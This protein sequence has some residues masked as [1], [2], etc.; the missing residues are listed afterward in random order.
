ML[1]IRKAL[2]SAGLERLFPE[3]RGKTLL[4]E[5][6][7]VVL[8]KLK[9][10]M[11]PDNFELF[12]RVDQEAREGGTELAGVSD[13]SWPRRGA[14]RMDVDKRE[15]ASVSLRTNYISG[16]CSLFHRPSY[17]LH[18]LLLKINCDWPP[19]RGSSSRTPNL[20]WCTCGSEQRPGMHRN[21]HCRCLALTPQAGRVLPVLPAAS[22]CIM[23]EGTFP[24]KCRNV[25]AHV[26][27]HKGWGTAS[28]LGDGI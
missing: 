12:M 27:G 25:T 13:A 28:T 26:T 8:L 23:A 4:P 22:I 5:D 17:C 15:R 10:R 6:T 21:S 14:S 7:V 3:G 2:G 24:Q 1:F 11:P 19:P 16:V 20:Q 18:P 9:L